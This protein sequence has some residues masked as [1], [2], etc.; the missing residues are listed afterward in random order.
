MDPTSRSLAFSATAT[1]KDEF[2]DYGAFG[3]TITSSSTLTHLFTTFDDQAGV[4]NGCGCALI[5]RPG[6]GYNEA[7]LVTTDRAF[8]D[9]NLY[10]VTPV[11][12]LGGWDAVTNANHVDFTDVTYGVL[13]NAT[14]DKYETVG[15]A[16]LTDTTSTHCVGRGVHTQYNL[17]VNNSPNDDN[18]YY[19]YG[20]LTDNDATYVTNR[21]RYG[22]GSQ[23]YSSAVSSCENLLVAFANDNESG[24]A[25]TG[26]RTLLMAAR[27]D[28]DSSPISNSK[29]SFP[30][31]QT[32]DQDTKSNGDRGNFLGGK[33]NAN[34]ET[35]NWYLVKYNRS[36]SG[37]ADGY[38]ITMIKQGTSG[39]ATNYFVSSHASLGV[40]SS[41]GFPVPGNS[42]YPDGTC[43]FV[44]EEGRTDYSG[45]SKAQIWYVDISS[46]G[47][48]AS[49]AKVIN[50]TDKVLAISQIGYQNNKI[51][52]AYVT[53]NVL[54]IVEYDPFNNALGST[55]VSTQ[56]GSSGSAIGVW[57]VPNTDRI[58]VGH[59]G[60][61]S[62]LSLNS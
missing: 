53:S 20:I 5:K 28:T 27:I 10:E 12:G 11:A 47:N 50:F 3:K 40:Q 22:I 25:H 33:K 43:M 34:G 37:G 45:S 26:R 19:K 30:Y 56:I 38:K 60:G 1:G 29:T 59:A 13:G 21:Y 7:M 6:L 36:G 15:T 49:S 44:E 55:L 14:N 51:L 57:P 16:F 41:G 46:T 24:G 62:V 58:I 17:S 52:Y 61:I 54:K 31:A 48:A 35:E 42:I 8:D 2:D 23:R 39:S 18:Y 4:L 9:G 32:T